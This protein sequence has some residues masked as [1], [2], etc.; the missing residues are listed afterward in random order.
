MIYEMK[1]DTVPWHL[2]H[3]IVVDAILYMDIIFEK[4]NV[5]RPM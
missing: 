2:S 5:T 1:D 4:H 3:E